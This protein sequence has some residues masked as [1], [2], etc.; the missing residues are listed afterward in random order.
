MLLS[1][2]IYLRWNCAFGKSDYAPGT[3]PDY[4]HH[5]NPQI[6]H[7]ALLHNAWCALHPPRR[8]TVSKFQLGLTP[9]FPVSIAYVLA[10]ALDSSPKFYS[11]R[12]TNKRHIAGGMSTDARVRPKNNGRTPHNALAAK[13]SRMHN[14]QGNIATPLTTRKHSLHFSAHGLVCEHRRWQSGGPCSG[15]C[16]GGGA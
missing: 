4:A 7:P 16:S 15:A 10:L 3:R 12:T 11:T 6:N 8:P 5:T 9:A 2:N 14:R 13:H 1:A